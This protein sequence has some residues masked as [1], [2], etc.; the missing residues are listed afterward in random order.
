MAKEDIQNAVDKLGLVL[1]IMSTDSTDNEL[2]IELVKEAK[3]DL[4]RAIRKLCE[5]E[6]N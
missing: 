2:Q 4:E 3:K 6:G 5:G 1:M